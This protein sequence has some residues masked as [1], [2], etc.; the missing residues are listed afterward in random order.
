[1]TPAA[2]PTVHMLWHGALTRLERLCITS[3]VANGHPVEL[4][5]YEEPAGVPSGVRIVDAGRTLARD[6]I[7]RHRR[8]GSL[9]LFADW[10][11]YRLL[12][13]R[14]GIWADTDMVCLRP[15]DYPQPRIFGWE[16]SE[17]LNVAVLGLPA[18]DALAAWMAAGCENPNRILP[19]D[20]LGARLRKWKRRYLQGNRRHRMRWGEYGPKGLTRAAR[21]FG[22]LGEALPPPHFYPVPCDEWQ[23][24]FSSA[25]DFVFPGESHAVHLW[26]NMLAGVD[27]NARF[28]ADSPFETLCR[29]YGL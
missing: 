15:L 18:G 5:V 4:H 23:R 14:G 7:F 1:M 27:K 17:W 21:Y 13:E 10:F 16:S 11:R 12:H 19:Y 24:L 22:Y 26:N 20:G 28:P 9:A 6:L 25:P 2:L 29:R 3:F 8:T